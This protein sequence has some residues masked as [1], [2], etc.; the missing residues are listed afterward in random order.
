MSKPNF[1]SLNPV[2]SKRTYYYP[3]ATSVSF[4]NVAKIAV[5]DSS[6]HRLESSDGRKFIVAPGW[7]YIEVEADDWTF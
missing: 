2:E 4:D 3:D 7:R 1:T 6:H 5:S